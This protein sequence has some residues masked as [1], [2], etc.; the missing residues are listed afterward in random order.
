ML[1]VLLGFYLRIFQVVLQKLSLCLIDTMSP[2][3]D[4][5]PKLQAMQP[6]DQVQQKCRN[7]LVCPG[8]VPKIPVH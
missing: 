7:P 3:I 1:Q 2:R 6:T 4:F 5:L 8:K